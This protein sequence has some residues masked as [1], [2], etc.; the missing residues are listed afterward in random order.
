MSQKLHRPPAICILTFLAFAGARAQTRIPAA[1][2]APDAGL[3]TSYY[4]S[5]NYQSI[6]YLVCGATAQTSGCY[7]TGSI[8]PF[9]KSRL[10][11]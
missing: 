1:S 11:D 8:G 10:L 2:G 5:A 3:F 7:G 6:S 9:R 4:T